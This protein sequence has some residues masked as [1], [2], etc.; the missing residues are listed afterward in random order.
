MQVS[1]RQVRVV[2]GCLVITSLVK[3]GGFAMVLRRM[4]MVLRC[5]GV[6]FRCLFLTFYRPRLFR[7]D[8]RA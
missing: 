1:V 4:L 7:V 5:F 6:V 2:S 8:L 3:P